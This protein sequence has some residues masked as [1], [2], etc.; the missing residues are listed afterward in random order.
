M[1]G[2]RGRV[3]GRL[4]SV[5]QRMERERVEIPMLPSFALARSVTA[6]HD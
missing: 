2:W 5:V 1:K 3:P 4:I 6:A